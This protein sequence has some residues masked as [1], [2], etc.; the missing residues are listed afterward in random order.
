MQKN[1]AKLEVSMS[2]LL[3]PLAGL[4][5]KLLA[6]HTIVGRDVLLQFPVVV[7]QAALPGAA[8]P[9][10]HFLERPRGPLADTGGWPHGGINE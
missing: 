7:P 5:L 3:K 2:R 1:E 8:V 9:L 6:L 10:E 4:P